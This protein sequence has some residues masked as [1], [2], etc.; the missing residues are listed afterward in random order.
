MEL[1]IREER[2]ALT[3]LLL[4]LPDLDNPETRKLLVADLPDAVRQNMSLGGG[5]GIFIRSLVNN[6]DADWTR[7]TDGSWPILTLIQAAIDLVSAGTQLGA[8]LQ[9]LLNSIQARIAPPRDSY[10]FTNT[11][12]AALAE[13]LLSAFPSR[14]DLSIMVRYELNQD[15]GGITMAN[16]P[17]QVISDLIGWVQANGRTIELVQGARR[18]NTSDARLRS[19]AEELGLLPKI[20]QPPDSTSSVTVEIEKIVNKSAHFADVATWQA[21]MEQSVLKVCRV[22]YP[23]T[24]AQGTGFLLGPSIVMTNYHVVSDIIADS[25][26]TSQVVLRFDYKTDA[27]GVATAEGTEY[28]LGADWLID[29]SPVEELDYALLRVDGLPGREKITSLPGSPERGWLTPTSAP[30]AAQSP[31]F[32]IQHPQG[33]PLKVAF[34]VITEVTGN[35]VKYRTNTEQGSSGAPGFTD[36][37]EL[38]VLHHG[39]DPNVADPKYNEGI[40]FGVILD[41]PKVR[42]ALELDITGTVG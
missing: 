4:G 39:A 23:R 16:N 9:S 15:L 33:K 11:Q 8:E 38:A 40:P 42:A 14:S 12:I 13:A 21:R 24:Q 2:R 35:R 5:N 18:R 6:L 36:E 28:H 19:F 17:Q 37:W 26:K 7:L 32:V 34:D 25:R 30:L 41:R 27:K 1:L 29:C 20:I 22:E 31:L 10:A 3:D